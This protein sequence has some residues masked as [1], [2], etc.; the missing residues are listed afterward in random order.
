[1]EHAEKRLVLNCCLSPQRVSRGGANWGQGLVGVLKGQVRP[2]AKWTA[3]FRHSPLHQLFATAWGKYIED[4]FIEIPVG[5]KVNT[6]DWLCRSVSVC[7]RCIFE[8][9]YVLEIALLCAWK[10]RQIAHCFL[11][12]Q[13][14]PLVFLQPHATRNRRVQGGFFATQDMAT[15]C[16]DDIKS[17]QERGKRNNK[18][19]GTR[20]R[21]GQ[22]ECVLHVHTF[23]T[24]PH[25]QICH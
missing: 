9:E 18:K 20:F 4:D 2:S 13:L 1:M 19:R 14:W 17:C 16:Q 5:Q 7:V 24:A 6:V 25:D 10:I 12:V 8:W 11:S 22:I 3:C 23:Q 15:I 21:L